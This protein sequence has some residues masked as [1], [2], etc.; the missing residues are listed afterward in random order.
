MLHGVLD[1]PTEIAAIDTLQSAGHL[2][3][4]TIEIGAGRSFDF[5][6]LLEWRR[7][8]AITQKDITLITRELATLVQAGLTLDH[9]LR[10]LSRLH[11]K[12]PVRQSLHTLSENLQTGLSFSNALAKQP[13]VFSNLYINMVRAG[14]FS[15]SLGDV[16]GRLADYLERMSSLRAHVTT[17]MI[18]PVILLGFSI[19]SLIILMSFVI[20]QFIPLFVDAGQ[21]LPLLT[22]IVFAASSLFQ[23]YWWVLPA[24]LIVIL[25]LTNKFLEDPSL[26]RRYDGWCL[27]LPWLGELIRQ[28]E[29]ARFAHSLGTAISNGVPLLAGTRL[30]R[31]VI[32]NYR[33]ADDIQAVSTSLEQGQSMARPLKESD[34]WPELAAQLIEVGETSGKLEVMLTKIAEIYDREV[35]T[36]TK[37]LLVLL[38]PALILLLGGMIAIIITSVLLALLSLNTL[39]I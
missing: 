23:Q 18:Y 27:R 21:S 10:N 6:R 24:L 26:R 17:T 5:S 35:Q 33:I 31:E 19:L 13:D 25:W 30:V 2:P 4:S 16:I 34:V 9:A 11:R 20:P 29:I 37:R 28:M 7:P 3:I 14:E 22:R 15:G 38:E 12:V 32:G 36:G 39:V 1:A 8:N